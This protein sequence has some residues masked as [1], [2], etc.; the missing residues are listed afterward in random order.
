MISQI[1]FKA[2]VKGD[3]TLLIPLVELLGEHYGINEIEYND[4]EFGI[5]QV[6]CTLTNPNECQV[7]QE[8]IEIVAVDLNVSTVVVLDWSTK[9]RFV[10]YARDIIAFILWKRYDLS[11]VHIGKLMHAKSHS[12]ACVASR[13]FSNVP[14]I[15]VC[16]LVEAYTACKKCY[17][18]TKG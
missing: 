18:S 11:F 7:L 8:L 10:S 16:T 4:G 5:G 9:G 17:I 1:T 14:N 12:S 6:V 15:K 3:A 13:K 2:A